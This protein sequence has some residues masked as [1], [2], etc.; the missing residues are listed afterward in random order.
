MSSRPVLKPIEVVRILKTL[1]FTEARQKG[2]HKQ[3]KHPDGRQTTVPF[4]KGQDLSPILLRKIADDI[5]LHIDEF[6]SY[7]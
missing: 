1:G 2:S 3:Y 5:H 7:L 6:L 4:H